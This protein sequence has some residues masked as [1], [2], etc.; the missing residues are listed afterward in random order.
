MS[1]NSDDDNGIG[2][3]PK[4]FEQGRSAM[5]PIIVRPSTRPQTDAERD[6]GHITGRAR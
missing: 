1:K 4:S 3:W 2:P 5:I 6:V